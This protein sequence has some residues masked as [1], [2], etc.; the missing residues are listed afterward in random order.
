[1]AT[2]SLT[3]GIAITTVTLG[4]VDA[5]VNPVLPY[6]AAS[7]LYSVRFLGGA[8][9][10][11]Q[12]FARLRGATDIHAGLSPITIRYSIVQARTSTS[13]QTVVGVGRDFF[14]VLGATPAR[15][16]WFVPEARSPEDAGAVISYA[17]W[18]REF[19]ADDSIPSLRVQV[20]GRA[21]S[22]VGVAP[23]E[24]SYPYGAAV[25]LEL[26]S[27]A[28]Q[29]G[30]GV[31]RLSAVMRLAPGL[32][33]AV[34]A[35]RLEVLAE[36]GATDAAQRRTA[37]ELR[38]LRSSSPKIQEFQVAMAAGAVAV[39][40]IACANLA[41]LMLVRGLGRRQE[42]A[43]RLA[44]GASRADLERQVLFEAGIVAALGGVLGSLLAWTGTKL[45]LAYVPAGDVSRTASAARFN[46]HSWAYAVVATCLA[47]L[48]VGVWPAWRASDVSVGAAM[49]DGSATTTSAGQRSHRVIVIAELALA[50]S[51]MMAA[52]LMGKAARRVAG[53]DFGYDA[54][55]LLTASVLVRS[56]VVVRNSA[57]NSVYSAMLA[58]AAAQPG[59]AGAASLAWDAPV[60]GVAIAATG[61]GRVRR[62]PLRLYLSVSPDFL[63]VFRIPVVQGRDFFGGDAAG[64][65]VAIIDEATARRLWPGESPVGKLLSLGNNLPGATW[66]PVV[67]VAR[68]AALAFN[69]DPDADPGPRIYVVGGEEQSRY[70]DLVLRVPHWSPPIAA[71]L[72]RLLS[73]LLPGSGSVPVSPWLQ[74]FETIVAGQ[75]FVAALFGL[76]GAFGLLLSAVGLYGVLSY[77]TTLRTREI[78][79]RI[80]MGA[81]TGRVLRGVLRDASA[82]VLAG[83]AIG[84]I[85]SLWAAQLLRHWL[86]DVNPTDA[87]SLVLSEATLI[88]VALG[89]CLGPALRAARTDP[90]NVLRSP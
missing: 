42:L 4:M 2:A 80:A 47:A 84:A 78:A 20:D 50:I 16:R 46:A 44:L 10:P 70:R 90:A 55:P 79:V 77:A 22:V 64:R 25:W 52:G 43:V 72:S 30:A 11:F 74:S 86:Y 71:E 56:D 45:L 5:V 24:M 75:R 26:P 1:M 37:Y 14:R 19:G 32:P 35:S 6:R 33:A 21:Y 57:V 38:S 63:R 81:D 34:A 73:D 76:F 8:E 59:V 51:L 40:L 27:A 66:I 60:G 87:A 15:G 54:K 29:S 65:G 28:E 31:E 85:F 23:P 58:R 9:S 69:A 7:E 3:L 17:F 83:V 12:R 41:N 88:V 82:L 68:G 49:K 18:R 48:V 13:A 61:D 89:A 53:F 36:Q 67:G 39:L 62:M